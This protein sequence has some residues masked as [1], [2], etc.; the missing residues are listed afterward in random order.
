MAFSL[1]VDEPQL[2]SGFHWT[3]IYNWYVVRCGCKNGYEKDTCSHDTTCSKYAN[4]SRLY[5]QHTFGEP[6]RP[7]HFDSAKIIHMSSINYETNGYEYTLDLP[8]I[9]H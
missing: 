1:A 5:N 2:K 8:I 6:I 9:S 4:H 7:L 3:T